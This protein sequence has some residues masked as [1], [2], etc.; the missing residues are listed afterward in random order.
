MPAAPDDPPAP[1]ELVTLQVWRVPTGA[2]PRALGRMAL[3]R[4]SLR[5]TPGL[6]FGKLLGTGYGVT[7]A[8]GDANLRRWALLACW[9]SHADARRFD[10]AAMPARW[11]RLAE[12]QWRVELRPLASHGRWSRRAP[13]GHPQPERWGGPVAAL[14]RARLAPRR[15]LTFWRSVP[16]VAAALRDQ[17]GVLA[18]FGIGEAPVGWQGTFSA[19]RDQA[20]L[21]SFAY[22]C[23]AHREVIERTGQVGWYAEELFA[24]FA[25]V[26]SD[27]TLDGRDPL[28]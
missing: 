27:G 3:D 5:H 25:I 1:P 14:T 6:R 11:R 22:D 7:F 13:F 20:A 8:P 18:A 28:A 23:A 4:R 12:E 26:G 21:R 10:S 16:P 9:A 19:W 2:V 15:A 24:R 17:D